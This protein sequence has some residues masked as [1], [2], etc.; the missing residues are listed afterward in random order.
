MRNLPKVRDS[1]S[2]DDVI[3]KKS[4]RDRKKPKTVYQTQ[5]DRHTHT[6]THAQ[7]ER[8]AEKNTNI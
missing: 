1:H 6:H 4:L 3:G 5:T 8:K 7:S 2:K